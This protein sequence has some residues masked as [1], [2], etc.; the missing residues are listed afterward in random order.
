MDWIRWLERDSVL[1]LEPNRKIGVMWEYA[2]TTKVKIQ[3]QDP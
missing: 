2:T 1:A 3:I